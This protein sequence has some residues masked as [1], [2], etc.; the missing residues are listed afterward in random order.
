MNRHLLLAAAVAAVAAAGPML[1]SGAA[2]TDAAPAATTTLQDAGINPQTGAAAMLLTDGNGEPLD[3]DAG[4]TYKVAEDDNGVSITEHSVIYNNDALTAAGVA[5][6][7]APDI[8]WALTN[9]DTGQ[10]MNAGSG[11]TQYSGVIKTPGYYNLANSGVTPV[12]S[13]DSVA[14]WGA[15]GTS[16]PAPAALQSGTNMELEVTDITAPSMKVSII[17]EDYHERNSVIV[18]EDPANKDAPKHAN[19]TVKFTVKGKNWTSRSADFEGAPAL[20]L[21]FS[22]PGGMIK[23][24]D[25][26]AVADS[27]QAA[28]VRVQNEYTMSSALNAGLEGGLFVPVSVRCNFNAEILDD[29]DPR[30][31]FRERIGSSWRLVINEDGTETRYEKAPSYVFRRTNYPAQPGD[32]SYSLEAEGWDGSG[33]RVICKVPINVMPKKLKVTDLDHDSQKR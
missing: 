29:N 23:A 14:A 24:E 5:T 7:G 19:K 4:A 27:R 26:A 17:P 31:A 20:D 8:Q 16:A 13:T 28:D 1:L 30:Q 11:G 6:A 32:P 21:A 18:E 12:N 33:N 10:T 15:S 25:A 9:N 2:A 3:V 22:A